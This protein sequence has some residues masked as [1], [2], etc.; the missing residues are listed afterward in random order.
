MWKVGG[1]GCGK[2]CTGNC[3][4]STQ[5]KVQGGGGAGSTGHDE[6]KAFSLPCKADITLQVCLWQARAPA[7]M[8]ILYGQLCCTVLCNTVLC[9]AVPCRAVPC[10]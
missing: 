1:R 6:W 3:I 9:H 7:V 8:Q 5:N 4:F 2:R 10:R